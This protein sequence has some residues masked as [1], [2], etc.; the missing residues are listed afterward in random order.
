MKIKLFATAALCISLLNSCKTDLDILAPYK[1]IPV[2]Y[3]ILNH[4]DPVHYIRVQ[5]AF[6][7]A[8]DAYNFSAVPDSNYFT[9]ITVKL[10]P[11]KVKDNGD[12]LFKIPKEIILTDTIINTKEDGEFFS[13]SQKLY[14][15]SAKLDSTFSVI[16]EVTNNESGIKY[17]SFTPLVDNVKFNTPNA[18]IQSFVFFATQLGDYNTYNT[19]WN[20][21]NNGYY[22][23]LFLVF[24]YRSVYSVNGQLDTIAKVITW[25]QAPIIKDQTSTVE[26]AI[27]GEEFY[28]YL[29]EGKEKDEA[30]HLAKSDFIK[31]A[32]N[33]RAHPFLWAPYILI[34]DSSSIVLSTSNL[35]IY[36]TVGGAILILAVGFILLYK[37]YTK[38]SA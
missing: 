22:T 11:F 4:T 26:T 17:K 1:S 35:W 28:K 3:G 32:D 10:I 34:G 12:T 27:P 29:K 30:L 25:K 33:N 6:L 9:D 14:K 20:I 13:P 7:G 16:L 21:G 31:S 19:Q 8:G 38:K 37:K 18:N 36:I 2:I 15:T 23:E 5:K 24:N